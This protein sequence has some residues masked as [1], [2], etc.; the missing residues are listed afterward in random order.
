MYKLNRNFKKT[1]KDIT[2]YP[3]RYNII[4]S[5]VV[6]TRKFYQYCFILGNFKTSKTQ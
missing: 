4:Y 1:Q 6:R 3:Q 5:V 2:I